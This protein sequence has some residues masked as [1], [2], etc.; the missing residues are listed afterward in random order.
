[1]CRISIE[2]VKNANRRTIIR[3]REG[4]VAPC[5]KLSNGIE[6][7]VF[8]SGRV[9]RKNISDNQINEAYRKAVMAHVEK[10]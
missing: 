5:N 4:L 9:Y 10:V 8:Y 2:T 3:Y 1:M 7:K 6:V